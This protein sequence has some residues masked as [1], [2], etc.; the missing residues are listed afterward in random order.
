EPDRIWRPHTN[1]NRA[2]GGAYLAGGNT[3]QRPLHDVTDTGR[4]ESSARRLRRTD[5]QQYLRA[6]FAHTIEQILDSGDLAERIADRA[7]VGLELVQVV[8]EQLDLD[9]TRGA[10]EIVDYI[11]QNLH[12]L[13]MQPGYG[14]GDLAANVI[15]HLEDAPRT[16]GFRNEARHQIAH[17]LLRREEAELGACSAGGT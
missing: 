2:V 7:G 6:G 1:A 3:Q 14:S 5:M 8:P 10:G 9:R 13:D 11:R 4:R 15:H 16:L 12:K 17:V